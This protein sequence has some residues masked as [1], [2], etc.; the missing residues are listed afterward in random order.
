MKITSVLR[1]GP[2][3]HSFGPSL[4]GY[5]AAHKE[6]SVRKEIKYSKR[7]EV[8]VNETRLHYGYFNKLQFL[9]EQKIRRN[10]YL[11]YYFVR[12]NLFISLIFFISSSLG[13]LLNAFDINYWRCK[14]KRAKTC[15]DSDIK[16]FY[17]SSEH[18]YKTKIDMRSPIALEYSGWD[19]HKK[20]VIIIHGFNGTERKSPMTFVRN[21]YLK[22]GD[23]N[24][25][26]IDWEPLTAFPC[27]L[28]ALSNTRLVAQCGAQFYSHLTQMGSLAKNIHCVG[29]SLGAHVCGMISNHLTQK[30][31]KII[32]LDPARPLVDRYGSNAFRLT[33]DDAHIVQVIHTN[34]GIL[35]ETAQVGHVDFCINGGQM[36]P[37]C[38]AEGRRI[39]Q[40]RCSHFKS[41]CF[42]VSTI[43]NQGK[44]H[45]GVPCTQSCRPILPI[46]FGQ[47]VPMGEH[48]PDGVR[49][50]YCVQ[51]VDNR[52]C[53]FD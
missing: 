11:L 45:R 13:I 5:I 28:S 27:Y 3:L 1:E 48:T 53:P 18:K 40:A 25:F 47:S 44:R 51:M 29:H 52:R 37:S 10:L 49:G 39:R 20:N 24:V 17:Y 2:I 16:I 12:L 21:A 33:R 22:R 15:P 46:H 38:K 42:F 7:N 8:G 6:E 32:G 50:T 36:Q 19:P 35:G 30:M 31:Y 34:A 26:T 23:Y 4:C 14:I 43:S 9:Q 41:V